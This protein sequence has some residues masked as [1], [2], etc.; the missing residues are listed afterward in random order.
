MSVLDGDLVYGTAVS[1][2]GTFVA[3]GTASGSVVVWNTV[4]GTIVGRAQLSDR[5]ITGL[6]SSDDGQI[7]VAEGQKGD[8]MSDGHVRW[9]M[10]LNRR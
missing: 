5:P 3:A 9:L 10:T 8:Y 6:A 1:L 4:S 2:N 7:L